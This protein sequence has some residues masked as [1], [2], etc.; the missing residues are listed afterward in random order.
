MALSVSKGQIQTLVDLCIAFGQISLA[1]IAIPFFLQ[2]Q[3]P[4]LAILGL[5]LS[6]GSVILA[7]GLSKKL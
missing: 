5:V 6:M 4:V 3:N 7:I 2:D 1:S